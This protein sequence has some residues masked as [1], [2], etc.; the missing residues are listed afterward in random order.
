MS[1]KRLDLT[2]SAL[3]EASAAFAGHAQC[4]A[5]VSAPNGVT[6]EAESLTGS[7]P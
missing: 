6:L 7:P 5:D 1:I 4:Y 3:A 2:K